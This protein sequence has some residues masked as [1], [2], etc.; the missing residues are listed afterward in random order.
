MATTMKRPGHQQGA[1]RLP[2]RN[3]FL[4]KPDKRTTPS[5][6]SELAELSRLLIEGLKSR[7]ARR[8]GSSLGMPDRTP[9][10]IVITDP[11]GRVI[12]ANGAAL[13]ILH[14]AELYLR[15]TTCDMLFAEG[16]DCPHKAIS[17]QTPTAE[18]DIISRAGD[19]LLSVRASRFEDS[20]GHVCGFLHMVRVSR[21]LE[22][23]EWAN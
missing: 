23:T 18:R 20:N 11:L 9:D 5:T 15:G 21:E 14:P 17:Q 2:G 12:L 22:R 4:S 1:G 16:M 19:R 6:P 3:P 7:L 8:D 13:K 10:S